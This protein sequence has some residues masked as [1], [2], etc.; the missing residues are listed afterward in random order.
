M[1]EYFDRGPNGQHYL[2]RL[3]VAGATKGS[4]RAIESI[5]EI[6]RDRLAGRYELEVVDVYQLPKLARGD[7]IVAVPTLIKQL[8][9]PV[10]RLVG[11]LSDRE[12][13]LFGLD[14]KER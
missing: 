2:L 7:Q 13:V 1:S 3:Y 4:A 9:A 8:P 6:C 12:R 5:R 14:L 11:D 10:R